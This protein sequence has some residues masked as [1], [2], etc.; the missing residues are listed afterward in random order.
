MSSGLV[1]QKTLID[2][3]PIDPCPYR[4]ISKVNGGAYCNF[5]RNDPGKPYCIYNPGSAIQSYDCPMGRL[6]LYPLKGL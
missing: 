2:F 6:R 3:I 1:I 4:I 5:K